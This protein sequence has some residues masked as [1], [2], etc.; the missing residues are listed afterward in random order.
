MSKMP[1]AE[2]SKQ[3]VPE[4]AGQGQP[5]ISP[6]LV[7][8]SR[9]RGGT[10]RF[11][12]LRQRR[13]A[14]IDPV[15]GSCNATAVPIPLPSGWGRL[16]CGGRAGKPQSAQNAGAAA[17][18][19][20]AG[21]S[22]THSPTSEP[23]KNNKPPAEMVGE[24]GTIGHG[25]HIGLDLASD[26]HCLQGTSRVLTPACGI[27]RPECSTSCRRI[28]AIS[29]WAGRGYWLGSESRCHRRRVELAAKF[30]LRDDGR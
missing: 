2:N 8:R 17:E 23:P 16:A 1:S 13:V 15:T 5:P 26:H 9:A 25:R 3:N 28:H 29:H 27:S 21:H 4:S 24:P 19:R 12:D 30:G 22:A 11:G 18:F 14:G 20:T 7:S 6:R 10:V